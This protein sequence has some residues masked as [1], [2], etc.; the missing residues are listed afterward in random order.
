MRATEERAALLEVAVDSLLRRDPPDLGDD[1]VE[2]VLHP[3]RG[4]AAALARHPSQGGGEQG[5]APAAVATRRTEAR[6]LLLDDGHPDAR[7]GHGEVVGG[8]QPRVAG[9]DDDDVNVEVPAQ[10]RPRREVVVDRVVP[11]AES[12]V[13][14]GHSG[15]MP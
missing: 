6:D 1:L 7:V 3:H 9:P 11:E 4:V 13:V 15:S 2:P 5:G 10:R 8:P 12:A 14:G